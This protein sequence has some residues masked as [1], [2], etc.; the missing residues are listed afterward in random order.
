MTGT[1]LYNSL[2]AFVKEGLSDSGKISSKR[3]LLWY[4]GI[5]LWSYVH[6]V[7]FTRDNMI[8]ERNLVID[9]DFWIIVSGASLVLGEKFTK[10]KS[11]S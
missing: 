5:V 1:E 3:G 9:Y 8:T 11:V 2:K 6:I 7:V 10:S 4:V